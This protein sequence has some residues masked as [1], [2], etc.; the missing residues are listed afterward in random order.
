VRNI[1]FA[2]FSQVDLAQKKKVLLAIHGTIGVGTGKRTN[3]NWV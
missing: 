2:K 1:L 3:P